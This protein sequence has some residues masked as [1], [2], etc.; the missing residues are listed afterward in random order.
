L[1][2]DGFSFV[3]PE[4]SGVEEVRKTMQDAGTGAAQ[5]WCR[6]HALGGVIIGDDVEVGASTCIDSGT[7]RA[8]QIGSGT[9]MD[10]L[11]HIGH[12]VILGRDCLVCGLV[13]V[14]GSAVVGD[15]VVLGGQSGVAVNITIGDRVVVGGAAAVLS[16]VPS[17]RAV[18]GY[19]ATK[20]DAQIAQYKSLRRLPRLF[21]DVAA[22]KS[23][24]FKAT[25]TD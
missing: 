24:V 20:M 21:R 13:G 2:G 3:T 9:K 22:L 23:A 6:I 25:N 12:N 5:S 4:T 11:V 8:T 15:H 18:L 14:A 10:S 19:P 17:G 7:I 1:G 16:N